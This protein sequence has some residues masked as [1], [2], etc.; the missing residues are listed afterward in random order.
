MGTT[1]SGEFWG[2]TWS[3]KKPW[4]R[5][6]VSP[7]PYT[8][9]RFQLNFKLETIGRKPCHGPIWL[10]WVMVKDK[11]TIPGE[12]VAE[13]AWLR[14]ICDYCFWGCRLVMDQSHD[15]PVVDIV[16]TLFFICHLETH[17][18]GLTMPLPHQTSELKKH[19]MFRP[20]Y[21]EHYSIMNYV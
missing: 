1:C 11:A 17:F 6:P 13:S 18:R 7:L 5:S 19:F 3:Q 16:L 4:I 20:L 8:A 12:I 2:T 9:L 10:L 14:L 21:S 15:I